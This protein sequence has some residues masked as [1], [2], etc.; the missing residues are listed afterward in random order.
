MQ[1]VGGLVVAVVVKYADNILKGFATSLSIVLSAVIGFYFTNFVPSLQ[2][3]SGTA[4]VLFSVY[5]YSLPQ[6]WEKKN[7]KKM[8]I[9]ILLLLLFFLVFVFNQ[10][11]V[12]RWQRVSDVI[13]KIPS[14]FIQADFSSNSK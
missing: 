8:A 13:V 14:R 1:A 2:F 9:F 6:R 7:C 11:G 10:P 3:I 4:V 12:H 5:L